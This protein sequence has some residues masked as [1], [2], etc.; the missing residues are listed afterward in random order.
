MPSNAAQYRQDDTPHTWL[1]RNIR[2]SKASFLVYIALLLLGMTLPGEKFSDP[3]G[4]LGGFWRFPFVGF[5]VLLQIGCFVVGWFLSK[6]F[7][8]KS[9]AAVYVALMGF[10]LCRN[11]FW[12]V[13]VD[14]RRCFT[15]FFFTFGPTLLM[16]GIA[17]SRQSR[18]RAE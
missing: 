13:E 9:L 2:L 18:W 17:A 11:Y 7:I 10:W 12:G 14:W 15:C 6:G 3:D 4:W 16:D 8:R 1:Q 5:I